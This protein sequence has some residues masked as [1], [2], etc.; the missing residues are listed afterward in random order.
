ME[1]YHIKM[2]TVY[3]GGGEM[4]EKCIDAKDEKH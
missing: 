3:A 2:E 1:R 4:K